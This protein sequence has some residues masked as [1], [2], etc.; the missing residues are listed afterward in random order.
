MQ[1]ALS[2]GTTL[3]DV[4]ILSSD[5]LQVIVLRTSATLEVF[6]TALENFSSFCISN[7]EPY[8]LSHSA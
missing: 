4:T 5:D 6:D 3:P 2:S 7:V 1:D 8:A